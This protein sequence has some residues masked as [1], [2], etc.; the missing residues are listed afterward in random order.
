MA[1]TKYRHWRVARL[2]LS[3]NTEETRTPTQTPRPRRQGERPKLE[4]NGRQ[5][6]ERKIRVQVQTLLRGGERK[7]AEDEVVEFLGR[8]QRARLRGSRDA[9]DAEEQTAA[10]VRRH[11]VT[12]RVVSTEDSQQNEHATDV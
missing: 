11:G 1:G 12:T 10:D 4:K 8:Q 9:E 3:G 7:Q 6:R 5:C 2:P